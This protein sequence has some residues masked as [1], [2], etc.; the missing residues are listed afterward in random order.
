MSILVVPGSVDPKD[1]V[2]AGIFTVS[3]FQPKAPPGARAFADIREAEA[4]LDREYNRDI[5]RALTAIRKTD[6]TSYSNNPIKYTIFKHPVKRE[7]VGYDKVLTHLNRLTFDSRA[8]AIYERD[9][10]KLSVETHVVSQDRTTGRWSIRRRQ[11]PYKPPAPK[12]V[13]K[14]RELIRQ[15]AGEP[16]SYVIG[17]FA[18]YLTGRMQNA[19]PDFQL[20]SGDRYIWKR[21]LGGGGGYSHYIKKDEAIQNSIKRIMLILDFVRRHKIR[22]NLHAD[23]IRPMLPY[24]DGM[25]KHA[26]SDVAMCGQL[27]R[28]VSRAKS[29]K[30]KVVNVQTS[31][32]QSPSDGAGTTESN[33]SQSGS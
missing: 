32:E 29:Q 1:R 24:V 2:I 31:S 6:N 3:P 18:Y 20:W 10:C 19:M 28:W 27:I 4:W 13:N 14:D 21:L 7:G 30:G 15:K 16:D 11:R 23:S 22:L 26:N 17:H 9:F 8:D 33:G 25:I 12:K 5:P